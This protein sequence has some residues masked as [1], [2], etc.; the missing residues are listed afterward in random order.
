MKKSP[1]LV[2]QICRVFEVAELQRNAKDACKFGS[3]LPN[4]ACKSDR[5]LQG[6]SFVS[7]RTK[8]AK[9]AAPGRR[10]KA[11]SGY[12]GTQNTKKAR[13]ASKER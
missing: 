13:A 4:D 6:L 8:E 12:Q 9:E 7:T 2:T 10:K 3:F 1:K 11:A 5:F